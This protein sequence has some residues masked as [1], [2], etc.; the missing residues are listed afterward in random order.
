MKKEKVFI[1]LSHKHSLK[2]K[3]ATEWEV[4]ET[5]EF[6]NQLRNRHTSMSSA[7]A[8]YINRKMITGARFGMDDYAK[9]DEYIRKKYPEQMKKLDAAYRAEQVP[10][11][12][13]EL[14]TD[15]FG[16]LRTKTVFDV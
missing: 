8:D 2:K 11:E 4:A 16:N 3:S 12:S 13:P 14:V 6:V 7:I 15:Q 9:F 1:V 5:I 10:D